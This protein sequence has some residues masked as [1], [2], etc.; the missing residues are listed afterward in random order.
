M[1]YSDY[2]AANYDS[3]NALRRLGLNQYEAK[4][5]LAIAS[6]GSHTAGELA[7]SAD[8]PRPRVYD[9]L[10][11]LQGQ[12]FVLIQQ[13]R[14]VKYSGLPIHDAVKTL[15]KLR[16]N[17]LSKELTKIDEIGKELVAKIKPP[18]Q[19]EQN[20]DE[21]VWTLKGRESIYTKIGGMIASA[22]KEIIF[23]STPEGIK[24]KFK[25]HLAEIEKARDLGVKIHVISPVVEAEAAKLAN[26]VNKSIPSRMVLADDQALIFLTDHKTKTEDEVGVWMHSPHF[27][28]TIKQT[29]GKQ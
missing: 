12:G 17:D 9:V 28:Q 21:K 18:Q 7:E 16:E 14:P 25:A 26:V 29:L 22:K 6:F 3:L 27:V 10:T 15:K 19:R 5:Y 20:A 23:S 1:N 11:S 2:M 8:I 4:A 24:S 13:G